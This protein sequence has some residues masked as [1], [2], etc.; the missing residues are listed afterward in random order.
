MSSFPHAFIEGSLAIPSNRSRRPLQ[1]G[2]ELAIAQ[3]PILR[4][5]L[6]SFY[7]QFSSK[8]AIAH[9]ADKEEPVKLEGAVS[10]ILIKAHHR[11]QYDHRP[12][13]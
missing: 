3:E 9:K 7:T 13:S 12:H 5:C 1:L 11:P 8:L 6:Q 2:A 10:T 4:N